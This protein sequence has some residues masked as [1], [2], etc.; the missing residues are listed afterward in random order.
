MLP[1]P[2]PDP[3]PEKPR[4]RAPAGACDCHAHVFGPEVTYPYAPTRGYTPPDAL[5]GHYLYMLGKLGVERGVL[6]QPSVYGTDNQAMLD[7]MA[8][9]NK[10][11]GSEAKGKEARVRLRGVAVVDPDAPDAQLELLHVAGVRGVRFNVLSGGGLDTG[12][13]ERMA[14]RIAPLGWHVQLF[15]DLEMLSALESRLLA[16]PIPVVIDH[17]GHV[18]AGTDLMHP[19]FQC[20]LR[21]LKNGAWA[22][23]SAPYR[24]S[25][26]PVPYVDA[27][28][29]PKALVAVAPERLVWATDWPHPGYWEH[30]MPNDADLLNLMEDWVPD[31]ETRNRI[32]AQNPARLY[33]FPDDLPTE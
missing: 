1:C 6:V 11:E 14:E 29:Y 33:D 24:L 19:G 32:L 26:Q 23:L 15:V 7:A 4:F 28:E 9:A 17:M 12:G 31:V 25:R 18:Q 3:S 22:K 27:V 20:L 13:L 2:P 10:G 5:L 8:E 30:P 21:M 16:L